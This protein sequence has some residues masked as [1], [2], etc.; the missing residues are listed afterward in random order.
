MGSMRTLCR[1]ANGD[2]TGTGR[3]AWLAHEARSPCGSNRHNIAM[4]IKKETMRRRF[5]VA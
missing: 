5:F 1:K 4:V 2:R 3:N